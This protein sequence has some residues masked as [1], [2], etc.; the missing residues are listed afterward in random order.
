MDRVLALSGSPTR[1]GVPAKK[2][3]RDVDRVD[4]LYES[5]PFER[6]PSPGTVAAEAMRR[7]NAGERMRSGEPYP[8]WAD[9]DAQAAQRHEEQK[10]QEMTT[11]PP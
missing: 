10:R 5:P 7:R 9:G 1:L 2:R 3:E 8:I 11:P 4:D 6:P